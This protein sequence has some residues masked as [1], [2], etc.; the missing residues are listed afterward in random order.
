[1]ISRVVV[2]IARCRSEQEALE[3]QNKLISICSTLVFT[4]VLRRTGDLD[5]FNAEALR[6]GDDVVATGALAYDQDAGRLSRMWRVLLAVS[7]AMLALTVVPVIWFLFLD[8]L[9]PFP[10]GL[11]L[12]FSAVFVLLAI[13]EILILRAFRASS[14]VSRSLWRARRWLQRGGYIVIAGSEVLPDDQKSL[15][16]NVRYFDQ[17]AA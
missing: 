5:T 7:F 4:R 15:P 2:Y 13:F 16:R 14:V 17:K 9:R 12:I 3:A 10:N 1:M 6:A 8:A 11:I